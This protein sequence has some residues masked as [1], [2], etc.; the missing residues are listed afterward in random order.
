MTSLFEFI[1]IRQRSELAIQ[2]G[3]PLSEGPVRQVQSGSKI[4]TNQGK[5]KPAQE[6][7]NAAPKSLALAIAPSTV[8]L[9]S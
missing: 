7:L 3:Y 2:T 4:R 6:S 9:D 5:R 8:N 1:G